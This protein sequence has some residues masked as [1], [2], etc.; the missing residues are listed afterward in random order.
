M[1][2]LKLICDIQQLERYPLYGMASALTNNF[3]YLLLFSE[4]DLEG[5]TTRMFLLE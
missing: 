1:G 4:V 5:M 3:S 2:S